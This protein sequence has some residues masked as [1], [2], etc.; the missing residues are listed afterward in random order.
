MYRI[1]LVLSVLLFANI[2]VKACTCNSSENT[3]THLLTSKHIFLAT[4]ITASECGANNKYEYEL[5]IEVNYKGT[6]PETQKI[7]SDC[8]TSCGFQLEAGKRIIFFTDMERN[9]I[10]FCD[11]RIEFS[12][13]AFIPTKKY[14]DKIKYTKLDYLEL[15]DRPNNDGYKAK[16]MVQ[17]GKVKGIVNVYDKQGNTTLKGLIQDGKMEGYYEIRSFSDTGEESWTGNYKNGERI[18]SWIYKNSPK[19]KAEKSK[20]I[21]YIYENGEVVDKSDLDKAAQLEKYEPK[22]N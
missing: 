19:D 18:G 9:T 7:Y 5:Y 14:L 1:I 17:D 8:V 21:L 3:F 2:N 20:F 4:I 11:L 13:T 12:D 16:M 22:K 10:S 6:L 15:S